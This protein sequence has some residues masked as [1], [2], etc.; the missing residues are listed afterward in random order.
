MKFEQY[1]NEDYWFHIKTSLIG[2]LLGLPI[3]L[4]A[5]AVCQLLS[6]T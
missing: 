6:L 4:I 2:M 1:N 3:C 5:G